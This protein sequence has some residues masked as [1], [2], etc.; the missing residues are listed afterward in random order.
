ML[1]QAKDGRALRLGVTANSFKDAGAVMDDMT[2]HVDGGLFPGNE[3]AVMP[4]FGGCMNRHELN[5][6]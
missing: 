1:R 2:H 4:D 5:A 3:F 6:P